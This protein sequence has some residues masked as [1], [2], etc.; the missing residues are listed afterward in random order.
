MKRVDYSQILIP[1]LRSMIRIIRE[2]NTRKENKFMIVSLKDYKL[3][4]KINSISNF[5]SMR[6]QIGQKKK[7]KGDLIIISRKN[8]PKNLN[9]FLP[10]ATILPASIGFKK[11]L[12][13]VL[14][15]KDSA[16]LAGHL[17]LLLMLSQFSFLMVSTTILLTYPNNF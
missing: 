13:P 9:N 3:Q 8:N 10:S 7:S 5:Q 16:D 12:L 15:I 1:T 6:C 11:E 17:L 4:G 14:R 2:N